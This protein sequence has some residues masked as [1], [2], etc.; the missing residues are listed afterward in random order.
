MFKSK[1]KA[2]ELAKPGPESGAATT[3]GS[4]NLRAAVVRKTTKKGD[5]QKKKEKRKEKKGDISLG[6]RGSVF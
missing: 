4:G 1:P 5:K 2:K 3:L 6:L